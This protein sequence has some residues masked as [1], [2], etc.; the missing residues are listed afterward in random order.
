MIVEIADFKVAPEEQAV[1]CEQLQRGVRE[2]LSQAQGYLGHRVL[3][4]SETPSRVVLMVDWRSLEDHTVGFRQSPAFAQWRAIIS[5]FFAA[6]PQV[7]HFAL[8]TA[9]T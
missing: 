8:N 6:A 9:A 1:F 2:V 5:P 3:A 7:E 4:C